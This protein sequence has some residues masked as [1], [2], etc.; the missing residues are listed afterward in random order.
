MTCANYCHGSTIGGTGEGWTT[1]PASC[2]S[3]HG[4]TAGSPPVNPASQTSHATHAGT[5]GTNIYQGGDV[6]LTCN[7]CH[8]GPFNDGSHVS[9]V[10]D[11]DVSPLASDYRAPGTPNRYAGSESGDSG[12][13]APSG[14]YGTCSNLACHWG[15]TTQAWN[16]GSLTCT[17]CHNNGSDSGL[18]SDAA[19]PTGQHQKHVD[20]RNVYVNDCEGCHPS[21][22]NTGTHG[23]HINFQANFVP[24]GGSPFDEN[25]YSNGGDS[26]NHTADNDTCAQACHEAANWG[27]SG[28]LT[29]T[30]PYSNQG[31]YGTPTIDWTTETG[32][33]CVDNET[34]ETLNNNDTIIN[35]C[36]D[37]HDSSYAGDS[38]PSIVNTASSP[39]WSTQPHVDA[40][41]G[42]LDTSCQV[43]YKNRC[44][45][46]HVMHDGT[47][48]P[49][50]LYIDPP[51]NSTIA[52]NLG[53]EFSVQNH[54]NS[55]I[56]LRKNAAGFGAQSSEA[57][58]CWGCHDSTRNS[59]SRQSEWFGQ[60]YNGYDLTGT[61]T[62]S[63]WSTQNFNAPRSEIPNRQTISMHTANW[64]VESSS[65]ADNIDGSGRTSNHGSY[66][67]G[68]TVLEPVSGIRCTYCHDVHNTMG[69]VGPKGGTTTTISSDNPNA[70]TF[71]Y[72]YLRG[73]WLPNSY[74][75]RSSGGTQNMPEVPPWNSGSTYYGPNSSNYTTNGSAIDPDDGNNWGQQDTS[76]DWVNFPRLYSTS[77]YSTYEGGFFIDQ[78]SGWPTSGFL[79][80]NEVQDTAGL[81][82]LCHGATTDTMDYYAGSSLWRTAT[83][84][85]RNS[86]LGGSAGGAD[87]FSGRHGLPDT[88]EFSMWNQVAVDYQGSGE[89]RWGS[90]DGYNPPGLPS[91]AR[92]VLPFG[93]R[94]A[95]L[96]IDNNNDWAPPFNTGWYGGTAG[97]KE[98]DTTGDYDNWFTT[99][100]I[101]GSHNGSSGRAHDFSCS[102]CHTPHASGLPALLITNC[103]DI[104]V[105]TWEATGRDNNN[106]N[107][108]V[109]P[110]ASNSYAR[111]AAGNCHRKENW[112]TDPWSDTGWIKLA[113]GQ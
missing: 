22:S 67:G 41:R 91:S 26:G 13:L 73:T 68:A 27:D 89:R 88:T 94:F 96:K 50:A 74:V 17:S 25:D 45:E 35:Y 87:I 39:N 37:C 12:G 92:D 33:S 20:A 106:N 38:G 100:G 56:N 101:A 61:G 83:N 58:I 77:V 110:T 111:V 32:S 72:T 4:G 1:A 55:A 76:G 69:P 15:T 52:T 93:D 64:D 95:A 14:T 28:S 98:R 81:C 42:A 82:V 75:G 99:T 46:C 23:T 36:L 62:S 102:K 54:Y 47:K 70:P 48:D 84:G 66:S 109:G 5:G 9:G 19:P 21:G 107:I 30:G 10:T 24:A 113:P 90:S 105:A 51:S 3:C 18:L 79:G 40:K 80:A 11:Y 29:Y 103:L 65:V 31:T 8:N 86:A 63:N 2:G 16:S 104:D 49:D 112:G 6:A 97:I 7:Q 57:E 59:S 78:N 108:T 53:L 44:L 34:G 71:N 43:N 60:A 85:H